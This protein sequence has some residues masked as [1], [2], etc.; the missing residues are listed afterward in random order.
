MGVMNKVIYNGVDLTTLGLYVSGDKAFSSPEKDYEKVSIPGRSGDLFFWNGK[1]KN[2]DVEYD[3]I[4]LPT[5]LYGSG[6]Y[7]EKFRANARTIKETLLS[8]E[9]Y[10]R[11]EDDY[12]P[13]EFRLGVFAGPMDIDAIFLQAG[14]SK[15]KFDCRPERFLK[16]GEIV[17]TVNWPSP[18]AVTVTLSVTNPTQFVSKPI[19]SLYKNDKIGDYVYEVS[20]NGA[21]TSRFT[22]NHNERTMSNYIYVDS[23]ELDC[24]YGDPS[25]ALV[26]DSDMERTYYNSHIIFDDDYDFPLF[27]PGENTVTIT[28]PSDAAGTNGFAILLWPRWY[29][30]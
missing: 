27:Y 17:K 4:L 11:I 2:V 26:I 3:A 29:S 23:E 8:P 10:V 16:S 25:D 22:I 18:S 21:I 6:T 12:N 9:G 30:L 19:F 14:K 1:Y 13:D 5:P 7:E 20:H 28:R 15:L 24:Y